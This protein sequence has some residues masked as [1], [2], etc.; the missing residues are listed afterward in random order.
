MKTISRLLVVFVLA[1]APIFITTVSAAPMA[2]TIPVTTTTDEFL[3]NGY[4]SLREAIFS[5][6]NQASSYGCSIVGTLDDITILV[7][8]GEYYL[9]RS[10]VES[11]IS[12]FDDLDIV[13]SMTITGAGPGNTIIDGSDLFRVFDIQAGDAATV[14]IN[15]LSVSHGN[16]GSSAGGGIR[17]TANLTLNHVYIT[18]NHAGDYGGGIFHKS[19]TGSPGST[20]LS[21]MNAP[22]AVLA[23]ALLT[24]AY[25]VITGN[26]AD[27]SGGGIVNAEGSRMLIEYT[28][29]TVN[30][31]NSDLTG[32]GNGG[33]IYNISEESFRMYHSRVEGNS[34]ENSW[35]GGL[36]T[37]AGDD[38]IITD[39]LFY[40]NDALNMGGNIYH[41][42][43]GGTMELLRCNI[44]SGSAH[45]GGGL[46]VVGGAT[47]VEN[48][49]FA[50]NKASLGGSLGGAIY[51]DSDLA[52]LGIIFSTI[53]ENEADNGAAIY[54]VGVSMSVS[55]GD[56]IIAQNE[57]ST[58]DLSN[59][60]GNLS[61]QGYNLSDDATCS[62]VS[63]GD[64]VV[65][66]AGLGIYGPNHAHDKNLWTFALLPDSP[67]I[68][69]ASPASMIVLD[70]RSFYRTVDGDGNGSRV[71]DIG[72]YEL[73]LMS[74]L[75]T[76]KR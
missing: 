37:Y 28:N 25:S 58:G 18:G 48:T 10:G 30:T 34:A 14:T 54:E 11:L 33:G 36:Y 23:P 66:D 69:A 70:E 20:P 4:C 9:T 74:F 1:L 45:G 67:A 8:D 24:L 65:P 73:Q 53:A 21:G 15:E 51:I 19:A 72:A 62:F 2:R 75:S 16:S 52:T 6:N 47:Y 68:D 49:T 32:S 43:S 64:Q 7:P 29:F 12:E 60:S 50:L 13:T 39:T 41:G 59:C 76:I 17:N 27:G 35:G 5:A 44:D 3:D 22:N 57:T 42:G 46:A 55:V 40:N 38:S 61:S 31:S 26:D 56:T 71:N 63:T